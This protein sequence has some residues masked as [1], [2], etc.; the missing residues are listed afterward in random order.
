MRLRLTPTEN[1]YYEMFTVL[2]KNLVSGV[3]LLTEFI[4][5]SPAD[6]P[7]ISDRMRDAEHQADESTHAIYTQLTKSFVTPFD[8]E[9]IYRLASYLDDVMDDMEAAV[10][11]IV[12]YQVDRLPKA[13][14]DQVEVLTRMAELTAQSMPAL[15]SMKQLDAYW[16]EINSLENQGDKIYRKLLAHLFSGEYE[17]LTVLKLKEIAEQLES[18]TDAFEHVANTVEQIVLKES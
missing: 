5:A 11:L 16:I 4:A 12:L 13:I 6:R 14:T 15:Q 9:D 18:A 2:A 17:A 1:T 7:A 3:E 10:D 8:R